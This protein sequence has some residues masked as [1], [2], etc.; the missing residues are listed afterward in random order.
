MVPSCS[1]GTP[2]HSLPNF[3][4]TTPCPTLTK[5]SPN[6]VPHSLSSYVY[7][8]QSPS[9]HSRLSL[10]PL[11]SSSYQVMKAFFHPP[12]QGP[13]TFHRWFSDNDSDNLQVSAPKVLRAQPEN[14]NFKTLVLGVC[15]AFCFVLFF[16]VSPSLMV[17]LLPVAHKHVRKPTWNQILHKS[18]N[19]KGPVCACRF[20]SGSP[21][22]RQSRGLFWRLAHLH[23]VFR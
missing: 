10:N 14:E 3:P 21:A 15:F 7:H 19:Q 12:F 8:I 17:T 1:S 20:P 18:G 22:M 16:F 6:I 11:R 23:A 4:V 2:P 5:A 9:L 13:R